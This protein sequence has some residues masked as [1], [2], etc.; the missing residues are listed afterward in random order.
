[1]VEIV[2]EDNH[3]LIVVK[4]PNLLTQGDQT[5]DECLTDQV[6]RYLRETYHKPGEAYLGLVH[7]LDRPV[8]GLVALAK[9]SKAAARLSQ[10]LK[11]HKLK[12]EYLCIVEGET[13]TAGERVDWL[14]KDEKTGNVLVVGQSTPNAQ[15]ARLCYTPLASLGGTTL[16]HIRLETGRKH[17]IRVQMKAM[18]HP[19]VYD[20]RYGHGQAGQ[21]IALWGALLGLCHPTLGTAMRFT[22]MPKGSAFAAYS[23]PIRRFFADQQE[24]ITIDGKPEI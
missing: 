2:Y 21:S 19:I 13:L 23:E 22:S 6:K 9:T 5:G 24:G 14:M 7:R 15:E 12:R 8:G 10:Q 16:C 18:G 11:E 20:M 4:P 17:Q 3:L 1:M